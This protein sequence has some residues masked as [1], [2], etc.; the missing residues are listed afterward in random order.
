MVAIESAKGGSWTG[1][2]MT[3]AGRRP[4]GAEWRMSFGT[5]QRDA[6]AQSKGGGVEGGRGVAAFMEWK[7][8]HE[9]P[10]DM[11]GSGRGGEERGE[12]EARQRDALKTSCCISAL[13][14]S[15]RLM[16]S[17]ESPRLRSSTSSE[18]YL[19]PNS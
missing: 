8:E 10:P 1:R 19:A 4:E 16:A 18:K 11:Q 2:S 12:G 5:Q 3:R 14:S 13:L 7:R 17:P 15:D 6:C 9:I